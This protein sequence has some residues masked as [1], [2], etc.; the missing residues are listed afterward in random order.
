MV[1]LFGILRTMLHSAPD[2]C[3]PTATPAG[4]SDAIFLAASCKVELVRVPAGEFIM[5][6]DPACDNFAQPDEFSQ[7]RVYLSAFAISKYEITNAQYAVFARVAALPFEYAAGEDDHP[8]VHMSWHEA[9][10]FCAWLSQ[11]SGHSARLPT[12]K[13]SGRRPRAARV[14]P[15]TLGATHGIALRSTPAKAAL[16]E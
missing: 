12:A 9:V 13:P 1:L 7:H 4:S 14:A 6:S 10:A 15:F 11:A 2:Y 3:M 16:G 5:D 8:A